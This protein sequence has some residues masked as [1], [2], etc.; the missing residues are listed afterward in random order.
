MNKIEIYAFLH[1]GRQII[2]TTNRLNSL[3]VNKR[4]R[5]NIC[6]LESR[7]G[8]KV[9]FLDKVVRQGLIE[10]VTVKQRFKNSS[11]AEEAASRRGAQAP[12]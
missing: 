4:Y 6:V 5:K 11:A 7:E 8:Y 2:N 12:T 3:E 10:E 9:E 1:G